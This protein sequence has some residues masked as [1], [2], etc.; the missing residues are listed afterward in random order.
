MMF[1][2][3]HS[4][5]ASH[6]LALLL[7]HPVFIIIFGKKQVSYPYNA[8]AGVGSVYYLFNVI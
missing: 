6:L 4:C 8:V 1:L 7:E 5:D 3:Y 2:R